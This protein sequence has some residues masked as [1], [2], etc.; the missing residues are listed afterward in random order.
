MDS[1]LR[2]DKYFELRGESPPAHVDQTEV[3]HFDGRSVH[4]ESDCESTCLR[5]F[6]RDV[7]VA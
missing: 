7:E 6:P 1:W 4:L 2:V 3:V 5:L